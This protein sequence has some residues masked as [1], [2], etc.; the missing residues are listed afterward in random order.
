MGALLP[1]P[2][3]CSLTS[4]STSSTCSLWKH[5]YFSLQPLL[6]KY[7]SS[8]SA[9]MRVCDDCMIRLLRGM[10]HLRTLALSFLTPHW[11]ELIDK[12]HTKQNILCHVSHLHTFNF[13]MVIENVVVKKDLFHLLTIFVVHSFKED[14]SLIILWITFHAKRIDVASLET[15]LISRYL[16]TEKVSVGYPMQALRKISV[17]ILV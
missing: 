4:R 7:F 13:D 1:T 9:E 10:L 12:D 2:E 15:L 14:T 6:L 8:F 3:Y 16:L 11:F 17:I 5:I